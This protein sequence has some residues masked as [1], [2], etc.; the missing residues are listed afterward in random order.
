MAYSNTSLSLSLSVRTRN[1]NK[2]M[3]SMFFFIILMVQ[4]TMVPCWWYNGTNNIRATRD[5]GS[6]A[7]APAAI[8]PLAHNSCHPNSPQPL[9]TPKYKPPLEN[10]EQ[11]SCF[12]NLQIAIL[13]VRNSCHRPGSA[14]PKYLPSPPPPLFVNVN[15]KDSRGHVVPEWGVSGAKRWMRSKKYDGE[16]RRGEEVGLNSTT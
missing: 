13:M 3:F 10:K 11:I 16:E 1:L 15:V 5:R 9:L 6:R 14:P 12:G 7:A 8:S 2:P 4:W